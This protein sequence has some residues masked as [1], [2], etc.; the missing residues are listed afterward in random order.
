MIKD[1]HFLKSLENYITFD[2]I[3]LI[4]DLIKNSNQMQKAQEIW[5]LHVSL[6]GDSH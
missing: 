4:L 3:Y 1:T 6:S 2:L 5:F